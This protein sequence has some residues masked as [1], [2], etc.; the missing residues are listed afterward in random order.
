MGSCLFSW[1]KCCR[2]PLPTLLLLWKTLVFDLRAWGI[3][4]NTWWDFKIFLSYRRKENFC[5]AGFLQRSYVVVLILLLSLGVGDIRKQLGA[6]KLLTAGVFEVE[7]FPFLLMNSKCMV[8]DPRAIIMWKFINKI[9]NASS[10]LPPPFWNGTGK[11]WPCR[12]PK[13]CLVW[14]IIH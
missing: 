10:C 14:V 5:W 11:T 6:V 8:H 13:C 4:S 1:L 9:G 3:D 12:L 7:R 2:G